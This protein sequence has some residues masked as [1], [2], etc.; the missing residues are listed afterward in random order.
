VK[1]QDPMVLPCMWWVAP[2]LS[3]FPRDPEKPIVRPQ[4]TFR[5]VIYGILKISNLF[6]IQR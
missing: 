3:F 1:R 4:L 2:D 5:L 6:K